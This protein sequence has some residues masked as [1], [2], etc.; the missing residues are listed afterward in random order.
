M[1][2]NFTNLTTF[3]GLFQKESKKILQS[4]EIP[5]S[6]FLF[7]AHPHGRTITVLCPQCLKK[8]LLLKFFQIRVVFKEF[9]S[10][11]VSIRVFSSTSFSAKP[12]RQTKYQLAGYTSCSFPFMSR[13]ILPN[14]PIIFIP[15][16]VV[17]PTIKA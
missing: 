15:P 5:T 9:K 8:C 12:A 7:P 6:K 3:S 1:I 13:D 4:S 17:T 14:K 10:F 16:L 2:A 11:E